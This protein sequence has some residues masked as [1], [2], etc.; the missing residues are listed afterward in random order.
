MRASSGVCPIDSLSVCPSSGVRRLRT[1]AWRPA[2]YLTFIASYMMIIEITRQMANSSLHGP[3]LSPIAVESAMT[4][5]E[6]ADGIPPLPN[7][8][9]NE[10]RPLSAWTTHFTT[11]ATMSDT[12]GMMIVCVSRNVWILVNILCNTDNRILSFTR[13]CDDGHS[14]SSIFAYKRPTNRWLV[15]DFA[16]EDTCFLWTDDRIGDSFFFLSIL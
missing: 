13:W 10:N 14:I 16:I 5:V 3:Y 1:L 9:A 4:N 11:M 15:T 6:W 2:W 12:N 8:L 7:I